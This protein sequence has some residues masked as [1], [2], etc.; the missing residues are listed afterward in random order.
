MSRSPRSADQHAQ[1]AGPAVLGLLAAGRQ[2]ES[3]GG[4]ATAAGSADKA[5]L[6]GALDGR[7]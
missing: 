7:S 5:L 3:G 1:Q 2:R 4:C 6:T